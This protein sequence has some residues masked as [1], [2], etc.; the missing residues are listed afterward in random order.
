LR[1]RSTLR[2]ASPER[3]SFRFGIFPGWLGS[4]SWSPSLGTG[5][6]MKLGNSDVPGSFSE[7]SGV[8][9]SFWTGTNL[10]DEPYGDSAAERVVSLRS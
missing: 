3:V 2:V 10:I 4:V 6:L 1:Q 5:P 9:L 8:E 7:W